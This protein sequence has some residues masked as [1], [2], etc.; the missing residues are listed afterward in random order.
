M[1]IKKF[2]YAFIYTKK[3]LKIEQ[4]KTILNK[5]FKDIITQRNKLI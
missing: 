5:K 3:T 2:R 1:N 4:T